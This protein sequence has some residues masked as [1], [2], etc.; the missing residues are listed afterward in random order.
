MTSR[1]EFDAGK[2]F[3]VASSVASSRPISSSSLHD[4]WTFFSLN[5]LQHNMQSSFVG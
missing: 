4:R 2:Y 3:I 5:L 1:E